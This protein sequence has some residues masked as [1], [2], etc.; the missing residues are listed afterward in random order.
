LLQSATLILRID[1]V[2][3]GVSKKKK[4]DR[5]GAGGGGGGGGGEGAAEGAEEGGHEEHDH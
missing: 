2:L 1:D 4:G 5:A 3:G